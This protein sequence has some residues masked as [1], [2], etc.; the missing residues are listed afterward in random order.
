M[1]AVWASRGSNDFLIFLPAV[2]PWI[3]R[4]GSILCQRH[5]NVSKI[6]TS[7]KG[8]FY[9]SLLSEF[10]W[11]EFFCCSPF[12]STSESRSIT[13]SFSFEAGWLFED[14]I[15]WVF[16]S[17]SGWLTSDRAWTSFSFGLFET[18]SSFCKAMFFV[19]VSPP[20]T[21]RYRFL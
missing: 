14:F 3:Y 9:D 6:Q 15:P 7:D 20:I 12:I 19:S 8:Y 10:D 16:L 21:T 13:I 1:T 5:L 18:L 17:S 11:I 4:G 2:D